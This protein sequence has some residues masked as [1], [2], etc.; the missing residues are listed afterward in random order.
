MTSHIDVTRV[1][2]AFR[3]MTDKGHSLS[4][5]LEEGAYDPSQCSL[6]MSFLE[7]HWAKLRARHG[8]AK[9]GRIELVPTEVNVITCQY[10]SNKDMVRVQMTCGV[11]LLP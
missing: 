6:N 1:L 7:P 11:R 3:E 10:N 5:K 4:M 9:V 8:G 2:P